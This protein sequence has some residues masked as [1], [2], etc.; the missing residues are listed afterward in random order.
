MSED[1]IKAKQLMKKKLPNFRRVEKHRHPQ[2]PDNWRRPKGHH[3]KIRRGKK[4]EMRIPKVGMKTPKILQNLDKFGRELIMI[5]TVDDL[6]KLNE[7]SVGI[8]TAKLGLKKR[9]LI[10]KS[11]LGKKLKFLNFIPERIIKKVENKK[12]AKKIKPKLKIKEVSTE[13]VTKKPTKPIAKPVKPKKEEIVKKPKIEKKG[14]N[15]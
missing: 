8:V 11:A 3:S 5:K 10:A 13:K 1:L 4:W 7:K 6:K 14:E 12:N 15:K 2:L 9:L